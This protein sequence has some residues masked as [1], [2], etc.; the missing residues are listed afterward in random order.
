M[1]PAAAWYSNLLF[2]FRPRGSQTGLKIELHAAK[3]RVD[4]PND[5]ALRRAYELHDAERLMH[6]TLVGIF[7][8]VALA[9][10]AR[11]ALLA[12]GVLEA[13]IRVDLH[14]EGP[15]LV[16]V[17]AQSSYER[18][19][20]RDLLHRSGASSMRQLPAQGRPCDV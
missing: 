14:Q 3:P 11:N 1:P 4:V 20:I 17:Q 9:Q 6:V 12:A 2:F 15:C 10:E 13:R 5:D 18:A 19:R 8:S 16:R 7:D